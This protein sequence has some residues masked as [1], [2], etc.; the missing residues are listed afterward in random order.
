MPVDF[1]T[2]AKNA[3]ERIPVPVL[4]FD[5][6]RS[7][8]AANGARER[9]RRFVAGAAIALGVAGAAAAFANT[10]GGW[11][12][13]FFGNNVKAEVQSLATVREPMI[14]DVRA[15]VQRAAFPVILPDGLPRG[16]RVRGIA[17]SPIERPTLMTVQY[18]SAADPWAM[19]I[20]LIDT[21]AIAA[22]EK[23]G[24]AGL[25]RGW[26]TQGYHF[27]IGG[28]TV[29]VQGRLVSSKQA[30]NIRAAMQRETPAQTAEAF[31][32]LLPRIIILQ[33]VTPQV[34]AAAERIAP[35]GTNVAIGDWDLHAIP[36]LA[37]HDRPLRDSRTVY[38]T[39]IPQAQGKPDYRNATLEW[40]KAFA[41]S[42]AGVRAVAAAMRRSHTAADCDCAILLHASG[43][44]YT[45]WK[46]EQKTLNVTE[47]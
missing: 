3:Q 9:M 21:R 39:N 32:A 2:R 26:T 24:S 27:R 7:R 8:S 42:P 20:T 1:S 41:V 29:L 33:K 34:A 11:H 30:A 19:G 35:A 44:T 38:L 6:I 28:E 12:I 18:G 17:Y 45:V 25:A 13:W 14:T 31:N 5:V 4:D 10:A 47:L 40:P 36:R 46:I 15:V 37:A 43:A 23:M 22:D 16:L